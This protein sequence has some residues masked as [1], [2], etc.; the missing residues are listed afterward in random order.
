MNSVVAILKQML[1]CSLIIMCNASVMIHPSTG[2]QAP[3]GE[4]ALDCMALSVHHEIE[5]LKRLLIHCVPGYFNLYLF[6]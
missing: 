6:E 4:R 2:F 1:L 5:V 3:R